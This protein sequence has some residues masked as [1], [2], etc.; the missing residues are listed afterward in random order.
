MTRK[1]ET[2]VPER[3]HDLPLDPR[4]DRVTL[5]ARAVSSRAEWVRTEL[6]PLQC[7]FEALADSLSQTYRHHAAF[8]DVV[9]HDVDIRVEAGLDLGG[10]FAD[11]DGRPG[12]GS[13]RIEARLSSQADIA[14]VERLRVAVE[15]HDP[16]LALLRQ[17]TPTRLEI[18]IHLRNNNSLA[19]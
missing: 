2:E 3:P 8:F 6:A 15:R 12:P 5:K 7:V 10:L 11:G 4:H 9:L 17:A 14:A 16:V 13:L 1:F 18:S 19:A